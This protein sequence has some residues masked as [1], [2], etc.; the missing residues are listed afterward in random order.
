[1]TSMCDLIIINGIETN[2]LNNIDVSI[3]K[4]SI[5][6][7]IGP[8]G[9]G[10]S[11]LAYDTVAQIGQYEF[12]SMF[13]DI[14][15]EP[16]FKVQSYLNMIATI[17]IKQTNNNNNIRSTIGTY[18]NINSHIATLYSALLDIPYDYFILNKEENVCP[19]C[20]GL[21]FRKE[22]D[23]NRLID[24][25]TPLAKC[26]VRCWSRYR[27]FYCSII[28][29]FCTDKNIDSKKTFKELNENEKKLFLYGESDNKYSIRFKKTH[30]YS[31]RT[32]K[33]F[34]IL[35]GKPMI[36]KFV[37]GKSF[38]SDK[39][40]PVCNGEKFS[41]QHKKA[42][43][44]DIS[45]G[46]L[47]CT[48]FS[49]FSDW[50]RT[51]QND[52]EDSSLEFSTKII[53]QFVHQAADLNLGH[54]YLNRTIPS[55]S[56]GELQRIKLVQVFN[57]QLTD[58]LI[59]LDEPLAGLSESERRIIHRRIKSLSKKHTV[60]LID[61]HNLFY[62]DSNN[63]IALG[64]RSGK[65]GGN[66]IDT[67]SY[68]KSQ[69]KTIHY[70]PL[71]EKSITRIQ[72][73][74]PIYEYQ[75]INIEIADQRLNLITGRS[76]IGKS[77]LLREYL[78]QKFE[79]YVYINQKPLTGNSNSSVA[80]ALNLFNDILGIFSK[81]HHKPKTFFSNHTGCD[82]ACQSCLG[83]GLISL[84]SEYQEK[85]HIVCKECSGTGFNKL[86][87]SYRNAGLNLFD[88]WQLT[89]DEARSY[90]DGVDT[91]V[92]SKLSKAQEIMLGHLLVGQPTTS[93]S[94]GENIRVKILR[95]LKATAKVYGVDEPFRGLNNAEIFKVAAFLENFIKSGKTVIV[96]D[97]E[98][99]CFKYF[100]RHLEL[101]C[102]NSV[103]TGI[104][105]SS[106]SPPQKQ[107]HPTDQK[108]VS[109]AP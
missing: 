30:A 96:A 17:P 76:G 74:S 19:E 60:L 11:S 9:S 58:L 25:N 55:L 80:T 4:S 69:S 56:G 33:F 10:K 72:L 27:S 62:N 40:C 54:L 12:N 23:L 79:K 65:Y 37:P 107:T 15:R 24:Y 46:E 3:I 84:G 109:R 7:I 41:Q 64:E 94:G 71:K 26:P 78:P 50:I 42:R 97:H 51:V 87:K 53:S 18:F 106:P 95:S 108:S 86:L 5:N 93:L 91:N 59:V 75:G 8:S 83:T 43:L 104:L 73:S 44:N 32:T 92:A 61:H 20:R 85:A 68:I 90:F 49:D 88:I 105:L 2:N 14:Q 47:M 70:E 6:L 77:T 48:P 89:I 100:T 52:I 38:F 31:R 98:D 1:M 34:G 57:T 13:S 21:G 39:V 67:E 99:E 36:P 81:K 82:G 16:N 28:Q 63:I 101:T 35:T 103:M 22:L 102:V 45:I 66:I 29:E